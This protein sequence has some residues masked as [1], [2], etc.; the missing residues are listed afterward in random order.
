MT[1]WI[2]VLLASL[3]MPAMMRWMVVTLPTA[4]PPLRIIEMIGSAPASLL[5]PTAAPTE[6]NATSIAPPV[7]VAPH[8]GPVAPITIAHAV[9]WLA[10]ATAIYLAVAGVLLQVPR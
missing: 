1:A 8:D 6:A 2:V 4:A 9:D 10:V 3:T 5:P 7:A